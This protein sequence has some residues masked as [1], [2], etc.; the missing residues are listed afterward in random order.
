MFRLLSVLL[1][2]IPIISGCSAVRQADHRKVG[3][4]ASDNTEKDY[5]KDFGM[6]K[7]GKIAE[8]TFLIKNNSPEVLNIKNITSSCGCTISEIKKK[9]LD[10][11]ETTSLKVKFNSSGYLGKVE[12]FVY[13]NTDSID[14]PVIK[15][16]IKADVYK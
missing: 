3:L 8:H 1:L 12:Q 13:V 16:I 10:P 4:V 11:G 5:L 2:I 7:E 6:I 15:F 14:E 9:I